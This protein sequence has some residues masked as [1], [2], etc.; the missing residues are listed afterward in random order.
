M[1]NKVMKSIGAV[2]VGVLILT[3]CSQPDTTNMDELQAQLDKQVA[4]NLELEA[5]VESLESELNTLKQEKEELILEVRDPDGAEVRLY[6]ANVDTLAKEEIGKI[7]VPV[8]Q[9]EKIKDVQEVLEAMAEEISKQVFE[10]LPIEIEG[11]ENIDGKKIAVINLVENENLD[12]GW[13]NNYLQG[14]TGAAITSLTLTETFLQ[15]TYEGDWIDG[16]KILY[17]GEA[18]EFDHMP[19]LGQVIYR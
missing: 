5:K 11:I 10:G 18:P 19:E 4:I 9:E 15:K 6:T 3:G 1:K 17:Q 14:S 16:I 13:A 8:D 7:T 12:I 2:F